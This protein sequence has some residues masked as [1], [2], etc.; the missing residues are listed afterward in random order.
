LHDGWFRTGDLGRFDD[1]GFL[2]L[3]DRKKDIIKT[4]SATVSPGEVERILLRHPGVQD[5]AVIGIPDE[6]WGECVRAIIVPRQGV[7][8]SEGD[9]LQLCETHLASYKKPRS[10]VFVAELPRDPIGKVLRREL[11]SRYGAAPDRKA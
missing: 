1:E 7:Q 11:R 2:H 3:T 5:A 6:T 9:I 4:G 8:P 10:I